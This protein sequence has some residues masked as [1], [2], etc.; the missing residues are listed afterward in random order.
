MGGPEQYQVVRNRCWELRPPRHTVVAQPIAT[1]F[2][3]LVG[4]S[5]ESIGRHHSGPVIPE[6]LDSIKQIVATLGNHNAPSRLPEI[7]PVYRVR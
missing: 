6:R 7:V 1:S 4:Q 5:L 2:I 3:R